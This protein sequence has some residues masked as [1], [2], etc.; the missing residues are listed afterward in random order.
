M[1]TQSR[2]SVTVVPISNWNGKIQMIQQ[3]SVSCHC[4]FWFSSRQGTV[5]TISISKSIPLLAKTG[6][7]RSEI[8]LQTSLGVSK[9]S[10]PF[11]VL[12]TRARHASTSSCVWPTHRCAW[13][14]DPKTFCWVISAHMRVE[15]PL[16]IS[17][18]VLSDCIHRLRWSS[19]GYMVQQIWKPTNQIWMISDT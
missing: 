14:H 15:L 19:H 7:N 4:G 11:S 6:V 13:A 18:T 12:V 2:I 3:K 10:A 8:T 9:E 5:S 17:L 1:D 16:R